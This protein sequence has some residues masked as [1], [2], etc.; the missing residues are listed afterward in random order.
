MLNTKTFGNK[1]K[2]L[3]KMKNLTLFLEILNTSEYYLHELHEIEN[4]KKIPS[5]SN[6]CSYYKLF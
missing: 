3:H 6:F 2:I 1:I 5:I 4:N